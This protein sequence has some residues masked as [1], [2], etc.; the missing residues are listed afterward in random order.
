MKSLG[1]TISLNNNASV[2][3]ITHS[4]IKLAELSQSCGQSLCLFLD[5]MRD[6]VAFFPRS[7]PEFFSHWNFS[8]CI[9]PFSFPASP[10]YPPRYT[11]VFK[12]S[13]AM[14]ILFGMFPFF[15]PSVAPILCIMIVLSNI[16][17]LSQAIL[18]ADNS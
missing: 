13:R 10:I 17:S 12:G 7:N 14:N 16:R 6:G 18:P 15:L 5:S 11:F 4:I 2:V 8:F 3:M 9:V 1:E